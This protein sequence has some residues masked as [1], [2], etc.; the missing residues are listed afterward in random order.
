MM[1]A[2]MSQRLGWIDDALVQRIR[3]LNEQAKLPVAPPPVRYNR[4]EPGKASQ[5]GVQRPPVHEGSTDM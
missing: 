5:L 4:A 1:A 3:A 2:D